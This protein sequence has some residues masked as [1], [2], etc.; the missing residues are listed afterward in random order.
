MRILYTFIIV[1]ILSSSFDLIAER[2]FRQNFN[3]YYLNFKALSF[4]DND[5][6]PKSLDRSEY[7]VLA[8]G[9][10][11]SDF[12][13][14]LLFYSN[15]QTV[16]NAEH[17]IMNGGT[18]LNGVGPALYRAI[19][20]INPAVKDQYY[21]FT[22][23]GNSISYSVIDMSADDGLGA[24]IERNQSLVSGVNGK[25]AG[26]YVDCG[27]H[28]FVV[29]KSNGNFLSFK[30]DANGLNTTP[31]ESIISYS[32]R[33][34]SRAP[35]K[36]SPDGN[37]L[38]YQIE[39]E[40]GATG[41]EYFSFDDQTGIFNERYKILYSEH[42]EGFGMDFSGFGTKLYLNM[43]P[44]SGSTELRTYQID[45]NAGT[46]QAIRDSKTLVNNDRTMEFSLKRGMFG[47]V[48][49]RQR[50][51]NTDIFV[52]NNPD[53]PAANLDIQKSLIRQAGGQE[54]FP[55]TPTILPDYSTAGNQNTQL[56]KTGECI[57]SELLVWI[58]NYADRYDVTAYSPDGTL[59]DNDTIRIEKANDTHIGW[60]KFFFYDYNIC[61]FSVD[62]I[63]VDL[64]DAPQPNILAT[65]DKV[66]KGQEFFLTSEFEHYKYEWST[67]DTS[68]VIAVQDSGTY[69]LDAITESG[70]RVRAEIELGI[71]P[72]YEA[73]VLGSELFMCRGDSVTI[74]AQFANDSAK[75]YWST[76]DL[77]RSTIVSDT[78]SYILFVETPEGCIDT[79]TATVQFYPDPEVTISGLLS[80]CVGDDTELEVV[81]EYDDYQW[82]TGDTTKSVIVSNPGE[83]WVEVISDNGCKKRKSFTL[84]SVDEID[85]TIE[86]GD[87]E[88]C[89]GQPITLTAIPQG[90]FDYLWSTG[91]T[92]PTIQVEET[93]TYSV[94]LSKG[95]SC[96]G[97]ADI[98]LSFRD[99]AMPEIITNKT[100]FCEGDSAVLVLK[101]LYDYKEWST[102]ETTQSIVVK[103][104]GQYWVY[105][106]NNNGCSDTAFIEIDV[107]GDLTVSI[108][109]LGDTIVCGSGELELQAVPNGDY[110]YMWNTGESS[111]NITVTESG[112]YSVF[113]SAG[114]NCEG[115]SQIEV[116]FEEI[117]PLELSIDKPQICEG[118]F[119]LI[120]AIGDYD[121]Y[122]WSNGETT[123]S[124]QVTEEDIYKLIVTS[125][126]GCQDSA[127]VEVEVIQQVNAQILPD[128]DTQLC[129]GDELLLEA[130]P[131]GNYDYL[132]SNGS[133]ESSIT[134]SESG[135]YSVTI[136]S[137]GDCE[138]TAE[139][140]VNFSSVEDVNIIASNDYLCDGEEVILTAE[141]NHTSY[142]WNTG[143][144]ENQIIVTSPGIYSVRAYNEF[145][146]EAIAEIEI[147]EAYTELVIDADNPIEFGSEHI[148]E[149][150]SRNIVITN[151][152]SEDVIGI[153]EF[154][155]AYIKFNDEDNDI[156]IEQGNTVVYEL[157]YD[158]IYPQIIDG[159]AVIRIINPCQR[160][161]NLN[162]E[163]EAFAETQ[164]RIP[165][166]TTNAGMEICMPIYANLLQA[167]SPNLNGD[168]LISIEY[169]ANIFALDNVVGATILSDIIE[170]GMRKL[171]LLFANSNL[172]VAEEVIGQICGFVA[173]GEEKRNPIIITDSDWNNDLVYT[174]NL[175]GSI[176]IDYCAYDISQISTFVPTEMTI[177]PNP[178]VDFIN[179]NIIS[180]EKGRILLEIIDQNG[181]TVMSKEFVNNA[182]MNITE[183][184]DLGRL[185]NGMYYVVLRTNYQTITKPVIRMK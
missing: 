67:G 129:E 54:I 91:E 55:T 88:L 102:G 14:R 33:D 151:N 184:I 149:L 125:D 130:L 5:T 119:A 100:A 24:V 126:N 97:V 139:I 182:I 132:W 51:T 62:S 23:N 120:S 66:C 21:L 104:P 65:D 121:N 134:V 78:G 22:V 160:I 58:E 90:D 82:S 47:K 29:R 163:G 155:N 180:E 11:V 25:I 154:E 44:N 17:Q 117:E 171:E 170:N 7:R 166:T 75:Y 112:V 13:G 50:S 81:E 69:W 53:A 96:R 150:T 164:F 84:E 162:M 98:F 36:F 113:V 144:T 61:Q 185:S 87:G 115:E 148:G 26:I 145:G 135:T 31:V 18:N 107:S 2:N 157:Y 118:D 30:I 114:G 124:I 178:A 106:E 131:Q 3:W 136:S 45:L 176:T 32:G 46:E 179:A 12:A 137:G 74:V 142:E 95:E 158:R 174:S 146:C 70:C 56:F 20:M 165:D 99:F 122:L 10:T 152:S 153:F 79:D 72:F 128:G 15:G 42:G 60:Y 43:R 133:R 92:T 19:G 73:N 38:A 39:S 156:I 172:Q 101:G 175:P 68:K 64:E 49:F 111:S 57:G 48:F 161:Y 143:S 109:A 177:N 34:G 52:I 147:A 16:W 76:G 110:T 37:F 1:L 116:R 168:I 85:V 40:G 41:F 169:P 183:K 167:N 4:N 103:E 138:D 28:W 108:E 27:L 140:E 89:E 71:Y 59:Y 8:S 93:G 80:I 9:A 94:D 63:F 35:M 83:Y 6:I 105:V 127:E 86:Q 173:I 77:G 123:K 159:N 141:G 181:N